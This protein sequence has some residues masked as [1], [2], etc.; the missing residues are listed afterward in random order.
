MRKL[1]YKEIK[2]LVQV[3]QIVSRKIRIWSQEVWLHSLS[4]IASITYSRWAVFAPEIK[5]LTFILDFSSLCTTALNI[6]YML[7]VS[8]FIFPGCVLR[9]LTRKTVYLI[10]L[11][12][13]LLFIS[14]LTSL[15][16]NSWFLQFLN[17]SFLILDNGTLFI[18][19]FRQ[20]IL[21]IYTSAN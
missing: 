2:L 7:S 11:L 8:K 19:L 20:F 18:Q 14:N 17:L 1:R 10:S 5:P 4:H 16:Q 9:V 3:S 13:S 15:G 21:H 12:G 6:I